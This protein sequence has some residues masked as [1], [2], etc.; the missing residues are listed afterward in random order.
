MYCIPVSVGRMRRREDD[1]QP[2]ELGRQRGPLPLPDH[3]GEPVGRV[4][5]EGRLG[6]LELPVQVERLQPRARLQQVARLQ[7]PVHNLKEQVMVACHLS[8]VHGLAVK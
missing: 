4:A 8:T 3:L 6:Q 1:L 7:L 5:A 2:G